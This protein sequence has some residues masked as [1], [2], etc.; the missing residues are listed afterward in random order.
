M[1]IHTTQ[2]LTTSTNFN[3]T[4]MPLSKNVKGATI[5]QVG[6]TERSKNSN[7][8][9]FKGKKEF[10]KVTKEYLQD[11][12]K[13]VAK[14]KKWYDKILKS[15]TFDNMLDLM[16]HEVFIQAAISCLI[17][18]FLRPLTI[19]SLPSR[20]KTPE[21]KENSKN[22]NRYASAHSIA[23]GVV[24]LCAS[25][26]IAQPFSLGV[27]YAQ[28]N[29]IQNL[30]EETL[31]KMFP[32]LDISSIWEDAAK[33]IRKPIDKW[34]D[35]SG[36]IFSKEV[37]DV[38]K[39]ARA[40]HISLISEATLKE[41]GIKINLAEQKKLHGDN[42]AAMVTEDGKSLFEA[43]K[44]KDMFI[45]VKEGKETNFFSLEFIN[46]KFLQEIFPELDISSIKKASGELLHPSKWKKVGTGESFM[47]DL[48]NHIHLSS[49]RETAHSMPLYTGLTRTETGTGITK[50]ISYQQNGKDGKLG[51]AITQN[52]LDADKVTDFKNKLLT[53]L[54]DLLTRPIVATSTIA[55]LPWILK[56]VFGLEKNK[57]SEPKPVQA[58]VAGKAVA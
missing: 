19:M 43:L 54:P 18:V 42:F 14:E 53:W 12:I 40:K 44:L 7:T 17:C 2:N 58:P 55:L 15:G 32:H 8:V 4:N 13:S 28:K 25:I 29:L 51:T 41:K 3:S 5:A 31:K 1:K 46:E 36:N 37:K 57:P 50:Y 22:N 16:S 38:M 11:L 20:A 33:K 9:S 45:G 6:F 24:G 52:M 23:S 21:E 26:L 30:S 10:L 35:T 49:Y 27:K 34:L 47:P 56:N 39:V 48:I